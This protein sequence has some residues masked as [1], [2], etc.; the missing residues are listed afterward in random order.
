MPFIFL[1]GIDIDKT[2]GLGVCFCDTM[3]INNLENKMELVYLAQR[4]PPTPPPLP[5]FDIVLQ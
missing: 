3:F 4:P 2:F 1:C 5:H